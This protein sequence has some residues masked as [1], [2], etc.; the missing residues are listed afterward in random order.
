MRETTT[1]IVLISIV[2]LFS[3]PVFA[4]GLNHSE[5]FESNE[6]EFEEMHTT[7]YMVSG[8]TATGTH[9]H[10]GI[11]ACN[12]RHGELAIVYS[13]EGEY[14]GMFECVDSGDT[15]GL[16]SGKVIDVW[17][18]TYEEC[19]EWMTITKGKCKVYWVQ[20]EG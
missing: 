10:A 13:M 15:D 17:F 3:I 1:I 4:D 2:V 20:G 12:T 11:C 9:T 16:R 6:V 19:K 7:A 5:V 8:I 14:L 18:E